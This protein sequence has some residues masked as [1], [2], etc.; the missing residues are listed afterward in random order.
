[1]SKDIIFDEQAKEKLLKGVKTLEKAVASTLGPLGGNVSIDKRWGVPSVIHDGVSVAKEV[2]L[3]DPFENMGAQLV[4]EAAS[5][6][7]DAAGDGTTTSTILARSIV[8]NGF[9]RIKSGI[10]P[11]KLRRE[12]YAA[13]KIVIESIKGEAKKISTQDETIQIANISS[14]DPQIGKIV[15]EAVERVGKDGVISVEEDSGRE[16]EVKYTEGMEFDRGYLSPYFVTNPEKMECIIKDPLILITDKK[17]SSQQDVVSILEP[18]TKVTKNVVLIADEIEGEALAVLIL[19][20]LKGM[21]NVLAIKAPGFGDRKAEML[22]DIAIL[23]GGKVITEQLG[24]TF[25]NLDIE[26]LGKAKRVWA[27]KDSTKI[28]S[29]AGEK[30]TINNRVKTIR[31]LLKN[32]DSVF[33]KEKLQERLSK[34]VSGV[35]VISV[36]ANT[37][38]EMGEKRERVIDAVAATRAALEEGI[39]PGGTITLIHATKL[40]DKIKNDGCEVLSKAL[41][42]PLE[43]LL[44]NAGL[45]YK[46]LSPK[47][48]EDKNGFGVDVMDGQF[49][50]MIDAGIVEPTKVVVSAIENAVSVATT[51]L[52]TR[53]LM[54]EIQKDEKS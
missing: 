31:K 54:S 33:D 7:N 25:E 14:Q 51:I 52:T 15:A 18:V 23:T 26:S 40:L 17:I 46:D 44:G 27:D 38:A 3:K 45:S 30:T 43:I 16:I 41:K 32:T 53:V 4:K 1:M 5:K 11:M 20:K 6:T 19:N 49:K 10:N 2:I 12:I 24:Q 47:I 36:G 39:V 34:L 50:N 8:E 22:E 35:A 42:E 21:L 29:G 13:S 9:K 28:I 37:E 48:L